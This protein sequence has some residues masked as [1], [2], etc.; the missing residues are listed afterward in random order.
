LKLVIAAS[1]LAACVGFLAMWF[2]W[3]RNLKIIGIAIGWFFGLQAA[4]MAFVAAAFLFGLIA[5]V[6]LGGLELALAFLAV[7]RTLRPPG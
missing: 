7:R 4:V 1:C 5:L 2:S 3:I 6:A